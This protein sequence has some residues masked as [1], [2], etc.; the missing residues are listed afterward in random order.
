MKQ[1]I[2]IFSFL[3]VHALIAVDFEWNTTE[4][5]FSPSVTSDGKLLYFNARGSSGYMDIYVSQREGEK[6]GR[7]VA[8]PA[9][10]SPYGDET[11]FISADGN[12]LVFSSDR[13]GSKELPR[14]ANGNVRVSYDLYISKKVNGQFSRPVPLS[15]LINTSDH[16]RSPSLSRDGNYLFF[17]RFPFGNSKAS[18]IYFSRREKDSW[19]PPVA[20]PQTINGGYAENGWRP[21]GDGYIFSSHRPGGKGGWDLYFTKITEG[22]W[23]TPVLLEGE[24]NSEFNDIYYVREGGATLMCSD[25][26]GGKGRYDIVGVKVPQYRTIEVYVIDAETKEPVNSDV[27]FSLGGDQSLKKKAGETPA[28]FEIHESIS[29]GELIAEAEGYLPHAEKVTPVN[30]EEKIVI[31]LQKLNPG[32]SF[33]TEEIYF[34]YDSAVLLKES[35]S[36]LDAIVSYLKK[37]SQYE[38]TII[39]HTDL[40]GSDEYNDKLSLDRANSVRDYLVSKGISTQRLKTRGAGKK[41]PR[42]NEISPQADRRNRR[43]EFIVEKGDSK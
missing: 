39:G 25:R 40:N 12:T 3:L 7:P 28:R 33:E 38:L 16:E 24:A 9:V 43:T 27:L 11:P 10:N 2:A 37:H 13:D 5:E 36:I 41:Y 20:L 29:E 35:R 22:K 23:S 4:N 15:S 32:D 1:F 31:S 6:W 19:S 42:I 17:S 14:N 30:G 8:I 34:E 18:R 21:L 26:P